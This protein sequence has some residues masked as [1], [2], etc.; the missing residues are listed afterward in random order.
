MVLI[1]KDSL[2]R[3][4]SNKPQKYHLANAIHIYSTP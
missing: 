3:S 4:H 2:K 1:I